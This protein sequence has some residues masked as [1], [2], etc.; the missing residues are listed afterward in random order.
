ME[1]IIENPEVKVNEKIFLEFL[2]ALGGEVIFRCIPERP[3]CGQTEIITHLRST[4]ADDKCLFER[5]AF[6]NESGYA[7]YY[8]VNKYKEDSLRFRYEDLSSFR[9][10]VCDIDTVDMKLLDKCPV[11][12]S[13]MVST[14]SGKIQ[15]VWLFDKEVSAGEDGW[16][17]DFYND[18]LATVAEKL[19]GDFNA[20]KATQVFRMPGFLWQKGEAYLVGL[21]GEGGRVVPEDLV[22]AFGYTIGR[23]KWKAKAHENYKACEARIQSK[24]D[25]EVLKEPGIEVGQ[26]DRHD[27]VL[28]MAVKLYDKGLGDAE[29]KAGVDSLIKRVFVDKD[30]FLEGGKRRGEVEKALRDAA[31]YSAEHKKEAREELRRE[32]A[33]TVGEGDGYVYKTLEEQDKSLKFTD[34]GIVKRVLERWGDKL[35]RIDGAMYAYNDRVREWRPQK[36]NMGEIGYMV[37]ICTRDGY[38]DKDFIDVICTNHD[39]GKVSANR[40]YTYR[41]EME[42]AGR[43][44][45]ITK[46]VYGHPGMT[47][48]RST[49][50]DADIQSIVDA[51]GLLLKVDSTEE[52]SLRFVQHHDYAMNKLGCKYNPEADC[53]EWKKFIKDIFSENEEP[54]KME[55][56]IQEVF[57]YSLSGETGAEVLFCHIGGGANGKSKLLN[58]LSSLVG[59]YGSR[60]GAS[61]LIGKNGFMSMAEE[62]VIAQTIGKRLCIID[63]IDVKGKW[64]EGLVKTLTSK[65]C[66][67]R[68]LYEEHAVVPNRCKFHLGM[69]VAP[70]PESENWGLLRRLCFIPYDRTFDVSPA[71]SKRIDNIFKKEAAGILN[72]ARLGYAKYRARGKFEFPEECIAFQNEYHKDNFTGEL[73]VE[74][75]VQPSSAFTVAKD[76]LDAVNTQLSIAC[77]PTLT[78]TALGSLMHRLGFKTI[79][80]RTSEGKVRGYYATLVGSVA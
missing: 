80:K 3:G 53:P 41:N 48:M 73:K 61:S 40:A 20:C 54:E 60:M 71:E 16:S 15:L 36:A 74:Q 24:L 63:D 49:D 18:V 31:E 46:T 21:E 25:L 62:R 4:F 65:E 10:V 42:R 9:G 13:Y 50:F 77:M 43:Q 35:V 32:L 23:D 22:G 11:P 75:L 29:V 44:S 70:S 30:L 79:Q 57:G 5:L 8:S 67:S 14:S 28:R 37:K 68:R 64:S 51:E 55:E 58:V 33:V 7:V 26:G 56:F 1:K 6:L 19:G 17:V 76:M 69:N 47:E 34:Q 39:S 38:A 72:W 59:S 78:S 12:A 45:G 27:V 2:S 52:E 66:V